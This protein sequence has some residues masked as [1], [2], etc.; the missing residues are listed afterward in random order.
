MIF[1]PLPYT[2]FSC[3][4]AKYVRIPELEW[5]TTMYLYKK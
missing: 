3:K 2:I 4:N 5:A 1:Q